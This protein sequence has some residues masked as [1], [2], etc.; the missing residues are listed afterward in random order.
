MTLLGRRFEN[1]GHDKD[2][3]RDGA[4]EVSNVRVESFHA[5]SASRMSLLFFLWP[6]AKA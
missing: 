3:N 1:E 2:C 4:T 5:A 6:M